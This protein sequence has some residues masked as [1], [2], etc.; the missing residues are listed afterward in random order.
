MNKEDAISEIAWC[1]LLL[2][3]CIIA[4][5]GLVYV[6]ALDKTPYDFDTN[7]ARITKN[8]T[9]VSY[10]YD[11]GISFEDENGYG[12]NIPLTSPWLLFTPSDNNKYQIRYYC[13]YYGMRTVES[14]TPLSVVTPVPNPAKCIVVNG[15]CQ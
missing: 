11:G 14:I 9:V 12:Y 2:A 6:G 8:I 7:A 3:L 10:D 4:V 1:W 15:T 5:C 13:N